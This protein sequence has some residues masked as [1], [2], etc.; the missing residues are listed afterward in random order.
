MTSSMS[1]LPTLSESDADL[2]EATFA[3]GE[4]IH[5]RMPSGAVKVLPMWTKGSVLMTD[6]E[7]PQKEYPIVGAMINNDLRG[8]NEAIDTNVLSL[9]P[10]YLNTAE[11]MSIYRRSLS[12]VLAMAASRLFKDRRLVVGHSLGNGYYYHFEFEDDGTRLC[13]EEVRQLTDTMAAIVREGHPI[14]RRYVSW[15]EA[16]EHFRRNKN[17]Q[18]MLL[19][20]H[21]NEP[22]IMVVMCDGYIDLYHGPHLHNTNLLERFEL[23]YYAPGFLLRFPHTASPREMPPFLD[24]PALFPVYQEYKRW[25][26]ILKVNCVGDVNE[27]I[28]RGEIA[29]F[30]HIA[31]SLHDKKTCDIAQRIVDRPGCKLV[32]IAGPSSSGK[33]T[34]SRKLAIQLR[35]LGKIPSCLTMDDYYL[36][37]ALTPVDEHGNKDYEAVEAIDLHRLG[38]DLV[39]L[40]AGERIFL[41]KYDFRDGV[42]LQG[43]PLKLDANGILIMEGIHAI[44]DRITSMIAPENKF[45]I[46]ISA[47]TQLN[48]DDHNRIPTTD[49]RL[50]R[51]ICRDNTTR[52]YSAQTTL[53]RWPL[54]RAGEEKHIFPFQSSADV[55]FNSALDYELCVLRVLAEPL[56]ATVK[57][58]SSVFHEARRLLGFLKNFD[59]CPPKNVPRASLLREFIGDSQFKDVT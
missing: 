58:D 20:R 21:H 15:A 7:I 42:R 3:D 17:E 2:C 35:V 50:I 8:L 30:I 57:P 18:T 23:R 47:L 37:R 36:P 22:R 40:F 4:H 55:V 41:P 44:N 29:N 46:F 5:V 43:A 38:E 31:D 39:K 27:L 13:E 59:V 34:F 9:R 53:E 12:F 49:N 6:P 11:G 10:V 54:V 25:G 24:N 56:L 45:K 14:E 51:R 28:E 52:G 1:R 32:L 33:T 48:L 19:V 26:K 16:V